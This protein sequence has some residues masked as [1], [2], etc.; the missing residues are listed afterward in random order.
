VSVDPL[1]EFALSVKAIQRELERQMNDA[2]SPLGLTAAQA[3]ALVV[4]GLAGPLSLKELGELLIAE[5]G[6]PSRLVDRLVEAGL[7]ERR[8][9]GDD[10]RRV[11]LSLTRRGRGLQKRIERARAE[12]L[13]LAREM[14]GA[15]D[16]GPALEVIRE[17][18]QLTAYGELIARRRELLDGVARAG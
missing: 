10:R 14:I 6:H 3:D 5:A 7:V 11:E 8:P 2:M 15:R 16:L 9:A 13:E 17:L 18:V 12:V 4:I 1:F